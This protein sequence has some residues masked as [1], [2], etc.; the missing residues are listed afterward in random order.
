M[1]FKPSP[2][3]FHSIQTD[4][5]FAKPLFCF[6]EDPM[7]LPLLSQAPV[8]SERVGVNQAAGLDMS[9]DGL[10]KIDSGA[11]FRIRESD[12]WHLG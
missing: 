12:G 7:D 3:P 6:M 2:S 10:V 8:T 4:R 1:H 9:G 5:S 11:G